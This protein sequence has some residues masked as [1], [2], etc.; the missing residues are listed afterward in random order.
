MSLDTSA[1]LA[2]TYPTSGGPDVYGRQRLGPWW[3]FL[4]GWDFVVGKTASCAAMAL[5]F[6]AYAVPPAWQRPVA[7]A[8]VGVLAGVNSRGVTRTTGLSRIIVGVVLAALAVV[9]AA[10]LAGGQADLA[11]L[12]DVVASERGVY[13]VLQSADLLFSPSQLSQDRHAGRGP[14]TTTCPVHWQ[15]CPRATGSRTVPRSLLPPW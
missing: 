8:A 14:A 3:G 12:S 2:A 11:R 10:C 7:V 6:A 5:T 1:Q 15:R 4:A 13:G 9:V